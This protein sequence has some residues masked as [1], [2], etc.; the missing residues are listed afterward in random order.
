[1]PPLGYGI[2]SNFFASSPSSLARW[3]SEAVD[4]ESPR[5]EP[6]RHG[7]YTRSFCGRLWLIDRSQG[8]ESSTRRRVCATLSLCFQQERS[9]PPVCYF[10][11]MTSQKLYERSSS[12]SKSCSAVCSLNACMFFFS[13]VFC[14]LDCLC[15]PRSFFCVTIPLCTASI[16]SSCA[17]CS[18]TGCGQ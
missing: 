1:M 17:R 14:F 13:I 11:R 8:E 16:N 6:C 7:T 4:K 10:S 18:A 12:A 3:R 15:P 2:I 5:G 9:L